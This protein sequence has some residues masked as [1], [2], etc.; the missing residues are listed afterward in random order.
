MQ[1]DQV[2]DAPSGFSL[3]FLKRHLAEVGMKD[4]MEHSCLG[5][6]PMHDASALPSAH[7]PLDVPNLDL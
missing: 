1:V 4:R 2:Q 5:Q 7:E 6:Q 3:P